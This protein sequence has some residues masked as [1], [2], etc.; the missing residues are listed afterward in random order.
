MSAGKVNGKDATGDAS[1]SSHVLV[2]SCVSS[3]FRGCRMKWTSSCLKSSSWQ[4]FMLRNIIEQSIEFQKP[5]AINFIDFNK[6]FDS[7]HRESSWNI[8]RSDGVPGRNINIVRN[9]YLNSSCCIRTVGGVTDSFNIDTGARQ[10][11]IL[12]PFLFLMVTNFTI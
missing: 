10:G 1:P 12:S 11:C 5:M 9:L 3:F 7:I 4:I 2:R 6:A 8:M